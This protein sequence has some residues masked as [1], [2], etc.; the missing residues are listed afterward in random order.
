MPPAKAALE[1][2]DEGTETPNGDLKLT[3]H[4]VN[5]P[6]APS[7]L[8][9][10]LLGYAGV[11]YIEPRT[12]YLGSWSSSTCMLATGGSAG[13][14]RILSRPLQNSMPNRGLHARLVPRRQSWPGEPQTL[15]PLIANLQLKASP[16]LKPV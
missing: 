7:Y 12:R 4:H 5:S 14:F 6:R 15:N 9:S 2:P 3:V 10:R 11:R 1:D 13:R 8:H 16:R